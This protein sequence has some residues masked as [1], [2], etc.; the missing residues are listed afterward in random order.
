MQISAPFATR[1]ARARTA[2]SEAHVTI[3]PRPH[4]REIALSGVPKAGAA[5]SWPTASVRRRP[6]ILSGPCRLR[7]ARPAMAGSALLL[8]IAGSTQLT[9]GLAV[10][11]GC[12]V[13]DVGLLSRPDKQ[14]A[15]RTW[16]Q[17]RS[18]SPGQARSPA[19]LLERGG[20][21]AGTTVNDLDGCI[22]L[23]DR[24]MPE[25]SRPAT[26]TPETATAGAPMT[27]DKR[28]RGP[29]S[30]RRTKAP[31]PRRPRPVPSTPDR[32]LDRN[33]GPAHG[34]PTTPISRGNRALCRGGTATRRVPPRQ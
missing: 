34:N 28:N 8:S 10:T 17:Y 6:Q 20:T 11:D 1:A 26:P 22:N 23:E 32:G 31:N 14:L 9:I 19:P 25:V 30:P 7:P 21:L 15:V 29:P 12:I 24:R 5:A 4:W 16:C 13:V 33:R 3:D 27:D 18:P 2:L